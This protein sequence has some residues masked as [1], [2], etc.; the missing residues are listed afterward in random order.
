MV[1]RLQA[2]GLH[3]QIVALGCRA[4]L[5]HGAE[6]LLVAAEQLLKVAAESYLLV[7]EQQRE[8]E[9]VDALA[10]L[11]Y[12]YFLSGNLH[13]SLAARHFLAAADC[14]AVEHCLLHVHANAVLVF[15]ESL[16]VDAHLLID[17]LHLLRE[18]GHVAL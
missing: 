6:L 4:A 12:I 5:E 7:E 10:H 11:I 13:A 9:F 1:S 14:S 17:G 3:A 2:F 16:D 8:V 18:G 15:A